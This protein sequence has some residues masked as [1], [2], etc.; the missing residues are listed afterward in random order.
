MISLSI[1]HKTT[2]RYRSPVAGPHR[3]M[4]RPRE[5]RTAADR[6]RAHRDSLARVTWAHDVWGMRWRPVSTPWAIRCDRQRRSDRSRRRL[7]FGLRHRGLGH[8]LPVPL[9]R[10]DWTDLG[11]LTA[12]Q[13]PDPTAA[14]RLGA[15]LRPRDHHRHAGAAQ[16]PRRR[17]R[18]RGPLPEPGRRG[19]AVALA[20]LD[21][22]WG[23]C[24]DF[25]V[26]FAEAARCLGFGARIVRLPMPQRPARSAPA[27]HAPG[28]RSRAGRGWI[29]F[30]QPT[31]ASA[32]PT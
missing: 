22:G 11:A 14:S 3:L 7:G 17:R 13:Y 25:A 18:R 29:T 24:R 19:H 12:L 30:D 28:P 2:Y 32:A 6:V 9:F 1:H 26:L 8:R 16:G 10:Q 31:A 23:S 20:T 5:P 27:T 15:R 4:L 21:R